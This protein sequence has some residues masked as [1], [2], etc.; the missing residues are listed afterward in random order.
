MLLGTALLEGALLLDVPIALIAELNYF[1]MIL[2]P[3]SLIY[4][5]KGDADTAAI[6]SLPSTHS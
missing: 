2:C 5:L 1:G 4:F 6:P 3:V